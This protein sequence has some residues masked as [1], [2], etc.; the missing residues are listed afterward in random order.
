[1]NKKIIITGPGRSGTTFLVQLLTKLGLETGFKSVKEG[2]F[3]ECNA[4]MEHKMEDPSAPYIVK[5]PYL[6][7][8]LEEL[9]ETGNYTIDHCIVPLR[10]FDAAVNSRYAVAR[11]AKNNLIKYIISG[12]RY[13]RVPG[14]FWHADSLSEQRTVLA[15]KTYKLFY[16]LAKYNIPHTLL[17]FPRIVKDAEYLFEKLHTIFNT[18]DYKEFKTIFTQVAQPDLVHKF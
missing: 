13:K 14:G 17:H 5:D 12:Y 2:V 16:I 18:L 10:D 3:L 9:M 1:M 11:K 7:D 15:Q 8:K 6:C 4:G